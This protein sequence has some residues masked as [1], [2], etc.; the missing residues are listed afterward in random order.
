MWFQVTKTIHPM[1][2]KLTRMTQKVDLNQDLW[3]FVTPIPMAFAVALR[4][5]YASNAGTTY[6]I[7]KK[8]INAL[9]NSYFSLILIINTT[10]KCNKT[11]CCIVAWS[12]QTFWFKLNFLLPKNES[13]LNIL[14]YFLEQFQRFSRGLQ[15]LEYTLK[16]SQLISSSDK[17]KILLTTRIL[18]LTYGPYVSLLAQHIFY[19]I[20]KTRLIIYGQMYL[21]QDHFGTY[22]T[23]SAVARTHQES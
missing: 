18:L 20:V 15:P 4:L 14:V 6:W 22:E 10:P 9:L 1:A 2:Q 16:C 19:L 8:T 23:L 7:P 21:W 12:R 5:V 11:S 3:W 17:K 13:V